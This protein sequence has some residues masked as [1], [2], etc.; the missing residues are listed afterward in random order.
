MAGT[1]PTDQASK[2][3]FHA[4]AVPGQPTQVKL[5]FSPWAA[6]RTY[7]PQFTTNLALPFAPLTGCGGPTTNGTKMTF[8]DLNA[9]ES[10]KY[11]RL[12]ISLP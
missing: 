6:N 10:Q 11:Y 12:Q 5:V 4:E 1:D 8:T 2:L 9:T 3:T 7:T